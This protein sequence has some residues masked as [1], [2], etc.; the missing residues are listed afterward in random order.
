[1]YKTRLYTSKIFYRNCTLDDLNP[2]L[3]KIPQY[4]CHHVEYKSD[5]CQCG[6]HYGLID[7][8]K[9]PQ[10]YGWTQYSYV[11]QRAKQ[12]KEKWL[13]WVNRVDMLAHWYAMILYF[14][15][16]KNE[17]EKYLIFFYKPFFQGEFY[18]M[19]CITRYQSQPLRR[20]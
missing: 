18:L 20:I 17:S 14:I 1:M 15:S 6:S 7:R 3:E 2:K 11:E 16:V 10:Y 19:V 9:M 12:F 13:C 4:C 5:P 8:I